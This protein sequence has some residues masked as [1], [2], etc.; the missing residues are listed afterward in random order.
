MRRTAALAMLLVTAVIAAGQNRPP[1]F[2]V[3]SLKPSTAPRPNRLASIQIVTTPGR[4]TSGN[5]GLR[6]LVASAY[7]V[8]GYLVYG[9]PDWID[10]GRFVVEGKTS[11][12]ATRE[13]MLSMLRTMLAERFKMVIHRESREIP[14][15]ALVVDG[16]APKFS[17]LSEAKAACW[18][19]CADSPSPTNHLRMS[20]TASLAGFM[21]RQGSDRPVVDQTGLK[22]N[23]AIELDMEKIMIAASQNTGERPP[24]NAS[25][26][27]AMADALRDLGLK[28]VPAKARFDV[29]VID[30]AERPEPN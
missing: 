10:S 16:K 29:V 23:F 6:D 19:S 21:T 8:E 11:S 17:P 18:P 13:E 14:I 28:V 26:F 22:G 20:D 7:G 2:D 15:N 25:I 3:A 1:A 12:E 24:S 9:G 30:H 5:A 4:L 27:A